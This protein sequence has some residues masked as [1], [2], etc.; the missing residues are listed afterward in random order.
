MSLSMESPEDGK[1]SIYF[2][3]DTFSDLERPVLL[4]SCRS[5]YSNIS[6]ANSSTYGRSLDILQNIAKWLSCPRLLTSECL[7]VLMIL[8]VA[9]AA[10]FNKTDHC[11]SSR[12]CLFKILYRFTPTPLYIVHHCTG[13][14]P[15]VSSYINGPDQFLIFGVF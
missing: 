3:G 1:M 12:T 15:K 7:H 4:Q 9:T 13:L 11:W 6:S 10:K 2:K 14:S 8:T 5:R